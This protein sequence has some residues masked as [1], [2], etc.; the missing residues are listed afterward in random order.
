MCVCDEHIPLERIQF[1]ARAH[2]QK[3]CFNKNDVLPLLKS[4][5]IGS[6]W[7]DWIEAMALAKKKNECIPSF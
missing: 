1:R 2:T 3:K 7:L 6:D 4:N 5:G